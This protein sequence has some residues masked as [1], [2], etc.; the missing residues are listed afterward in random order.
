MRST[1]CSLI[2]TCSTTP[3][4]FDRAREAI[5]WVRL[6]NAEYEA[7]R[8]QVAVPAPLT[9]AEKRYRDGGGILHADDLASI[10]D[11]GHSG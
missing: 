3:N 4:V 5:R 11:W 10:E 7:A 6:L 8:S 9:R 2:G 1:S